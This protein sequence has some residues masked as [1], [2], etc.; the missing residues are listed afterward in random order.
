[1]L[2]L[3]NDVMQTSRKKGGEFIKEF[4]YYIKDTVIHVYKY[5]RYHDLDSVT[6]EIVL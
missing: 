1:M 6:L 2:Y 3:A 5:G 4:G